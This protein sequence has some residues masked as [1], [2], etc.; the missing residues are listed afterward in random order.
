MMEHRMGVAFL[1]AFIATIVGA[2]WALGEYGI[3][4]IGFGLS[5]PAGVYFAGLAFALRDGVRETLGV[6]GT[7]AAILAGAVLSYFLE[8]AR[9]FAI[10]SGIAFGVSESADALVYEPLRERSRMMAL[11]LSNTV[12]LALDSMLFLWLAFGSLAIIEG[13]LVGK[14]YMTA[15]AMLALLAWRRRD[16]LVGRSAA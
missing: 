2:N 14:F 12:G 1:A 15:I 9:T 7:F 5:A 3:V 16:L 6:R 13:Q 4:S 11:G 10:A 8:D